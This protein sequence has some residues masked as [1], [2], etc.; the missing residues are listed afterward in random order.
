MAALLWLI[1]SFLSRS[2][3]T[4][5]KWE[6]LFVWDCFSPVLQSVFVSHQNA[7]IEIP[8][9]NMAL[10]YGALVVGCLG[11]EGAVLIEHEQCP[12]K[13]HLRLFTPSTV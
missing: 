4:Y 3:V 2:S 11:H 13:R 10:G 5:L 9:T 8:A 6:L 12:N 1:V 7:F